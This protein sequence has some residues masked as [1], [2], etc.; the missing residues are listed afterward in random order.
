MPIR[1]NELLKTNGLFMAVWLIAIPFLGFPNFSLFSSFLQTIFILWWLY[2]GHKLMHVL[3]TN[4]IYHTINPHIWVHHENIY[5]V[6]RW[7][8]LIVES[9]LD[10]FS[11]GQLLLVNWLLG[12]NIF[13]LSIIICIS[14]LYIFVHLDYGIFGDDEHKAHHEF[15][16]CN[17]AP[18]F[19][20]I[21]MNTRCGDESAPYINRNSEAIYGLAALMI[22]YFLKVYNTLS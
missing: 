6:P 4:F 10:I 2:Y 1:V 12:F 5:N 21:L 18:S 14:L 22:T 13:S 7:V 9:L 17:Y 3:K 8:N 19:M 20:D 11:V 15:D 16:T